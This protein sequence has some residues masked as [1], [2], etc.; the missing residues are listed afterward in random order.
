MGIAASL[1]ATKFKG[2]TMKHV[3]NGLV[4]LGVTF[5]AALIILIRSYR[6]PQNRGIVVAVF[7]DRKAMTIGAGWVLFVFVT[8]FVSA[9]FHMTLRDVIPALVGGFAVAAVVNWFS[10]RRDAT[11]R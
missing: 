11:N 9:G 5:V 2:G 1:G 8:G 4:I 3:T 10:R 6:N 7:K